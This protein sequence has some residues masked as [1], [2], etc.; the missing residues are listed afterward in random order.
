MILSFVF[1]QMKYFHASIFSLAAY[2]FGSKKPSN[3]SYED[4]CPY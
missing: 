2:A 1:T 3:P 4:L